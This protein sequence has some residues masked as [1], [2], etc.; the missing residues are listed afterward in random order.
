MS[1]QAK[2]HRLR[3]NRVSEPGRAYHVTT[4]THDR[5]PLFRDWRLGR[6]VAQSLRDL[7]NRGRAETLVFVVMPDH[8]HWLF[9]LGN[10]PSLSAL[11][12]ALKG[13]SGK[14]VREA[15]GSSGPIWQRGFYDHAI[16]RDEDLRAAAR[17]IVANPLRAGLVADLG[18][19]PLWD[20]IWLS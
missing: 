12:N 15:L 6:L 5:T 7:Q 18:D 14:Q 4:T 20:A 11:M 9:T 13:F 17:Y 2:G 8:L 19:Y 3:K 16:R 10:A 1:E